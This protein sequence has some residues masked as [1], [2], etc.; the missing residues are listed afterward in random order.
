MAVV[1]DGVLDK[2]EESEP[3]ITTVSLSRI[4]PL[5]GELRFETSIHT[6]AGRFY[7]YCIGVPGVSTVDNS[8]LSRVYNSRWRYDHYVYPEPHSVRLERPVT[9]SVATSKTRIKLPTTEKMYSHGVKS[10]NSIYLTDEL[11]GLSVS[12]FK[13]K[14]E[15]GYRR[16]KW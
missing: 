6:R 8:T 13:L 7:L 15:H 16:S 11:L 9:R 10:F 14:S 5:I 4:I 2:Y 1:P 12:L 3:W